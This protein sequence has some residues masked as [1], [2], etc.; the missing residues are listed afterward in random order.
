MKLQQIGKDV[1]VIV[2]KVQ[3]KDYG[4]KIYKYRMKLNADWDNLNGDVELLQKNIAQHRITYPKYEWFCKEILYKGSRL[5]RYGRKEPKLKG[6]PYY[7]NP[8]TQQIFIPKT[9]VKR[10]YK[11]LCASITMRLA[12]LGITYSFKT[13]R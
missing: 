12:D 13:I 1:E 8:N 10:K 6:I 3:K 9:Y 7:Y 2:T 5:W 4:K 11:L